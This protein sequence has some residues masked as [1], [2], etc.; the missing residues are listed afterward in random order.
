MIDQILAKLGDP[1][2]LATL[3]VSLGCATTVL[4]AF[5]PMLQKD[6]M[7]RRIKAVSTERERIRLRE[8]ER[9]VATNQP[10][11]ALRHK[12]GGLSKQIVEAL[13][14]DSWLNTDTAKMKLAMAGYRGQGAENAFLFYRLAAP[15]GFFIFAI[16]YLFFVANL[17]WS[18]MLKIGAAS[19]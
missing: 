3:L 14:L 7:S 10:K 19:L 12:T 1:N 4:L 2:F 9:M 16:I 15:I 13:N 17:Q 8:R 18:F 11:L 6:D 5:L